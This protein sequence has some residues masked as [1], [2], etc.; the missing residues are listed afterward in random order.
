MFASFLKSPASY[1]LAFLLLVTSCVTGR[2]NQQLQTDP[3]FQNLRRPATNDNSILDLPSGPIEVKTYK[4]QAAEKI[5]FKKRLEESK[6]IYEESG[7]EDQAGSL[8][9]SMA[10][11][12]EKFSDKPD[13]PTRLLGQEEL[14]AMV[15]Y[16]NERYHMINAGLRGDSERLKKMENWIRL[17]ISGLNKLPNHQGIVYRGLSWGK[18]ISAVE[19]QKYE[20]LFSNYHI[21]S[22]MVEKAFLSSTFDSKTHFVTCTPFVYIIHSKGGKNFVDFSTRPEEGE[23]LFRPLTRFR[24]INKSLRDI[25]TTAC[26]SE[27]SYKK[28][29]QM[30]ITEI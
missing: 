19:A 3:Q 27:R 1:L 24:V 22:E 7:G 18:D 9:G 21:G 15:D 30:E 6:K 10:T 17:M 16:S 11:T 2:Q 29:F 23:V 20:K 25:D 8:Y 28:Q 5:D 13:S 26:S 14:A 4:A 12:L